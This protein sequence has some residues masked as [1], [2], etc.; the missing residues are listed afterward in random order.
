MQVNQPFN[1]RDNSDNVNKKRDNIQEKKM[2]V[3]H[4]N[5]HL[6]VSYS[7]TKKFKDPGLTA[8]VDKV[9]SNIKDPSRISK[10][11]SSM[12]P[13]P[14]PA[15][16]SETGNLI[17]LNIP[18]QPTLG[19]QDLVQ[20]VQGPIIAPKLNAIPEREVFKDIFS[21]IISDIIGNET[22][23]DY[24][25]IDMVFT[26]KTPNTSYILR[27]VI[28][29]FLKLDPITDEYKQHLVTFFEIVNA[30]DTAGNLIGKLNK[31]N[32]DIIEYLKKADLPIEYSELLVEVSHKL[33][34]AINVVEANKDIVNANFLK[35]NIYDDIRKNFLNIKESELHKKLISYSNN[36]NNKPM[37]IDKY[38][39]CM[40]IINKLREFKFV[41]KNNYNILKNEFDKAVVN[42]IKKCNYSNEIKQTL[43]EI[44][45]NNPKVIKANHLTN[46]FIDGKLNQEKWNTL[47]Q[48]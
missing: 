7:K 24:R 1:Q 45:K 30:N 15:T 37:S 14:V 20:G 31:L 44:Y 5:Q 16:V 32:N 8:V 33:N 27:S 2:K 34:D 25:A 18:Q 43:E 6:R 22:Q 3:E 21:G 26:N 41:E 11:P 4:K 19:Q 39:K 40:S 47:L 10:G 12:A 46:A 23:F 42:N 35:H 17:D 38:N 48:T 9:N 36:E 29:L 28:K 13:A